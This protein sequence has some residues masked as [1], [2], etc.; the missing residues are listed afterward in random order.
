MWMLSCVPGFALKWKRKIRYWGEKN[1]HLGLSHSCSNASPGSPPDL[2]YFNSSAK[3]ERKVTV[4]FW[5][6]SC[7]KGDHNS[8]TWPSGTSVLRSFQF[9]SPFQGLCQKMSQKT[10]KWYMAKKKNCRNAQLKDL[11]QQVSRSLLKKEGKHFYPTVLGRCAV[12]R[13]LKK[14]RSCGQSE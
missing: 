7:I 10:H 5:Q 12:S 8:T 1:R 3:S 9:P 6:S 4:I 2:L 14:S 13:C 11:L